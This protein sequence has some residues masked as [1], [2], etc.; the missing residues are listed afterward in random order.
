[1][2]FSDEKLMR[3]VFELAKKAEGKTSPNPLVGAIIIKDDKIISAGYHASYGTDHAEI[4]ALKKA[5]GQANDAKLY[6]NLEP[7]Y[8]F[9]LTP[10]CVDAVIKAGI[11]EVI[12]AMKDPNP[13]TNGKSIRKLIKNGIKVKVGV[14]AKEAAELNEGFVK[15]ITKRMPFV[16]AKSAQTLDGRIATKT[17]SSK[18]ITGEETYNYSRAQRDNFDA[19]LTGINTILKD[20]PCLCAPNKKLKK[21]ILDS[22]LKI[23]LKA[24]VFKKTP[25]ED[26]FIVTTKKSSP[27]KAIEIVKTGCHVIVAPEKSGRIDLKWL[28]KELAGKKIAS[29]LI[30]GGATVIGNALKNNLVDKMH[31]YVAPKIV[32]DQKALSS[33]VGFDVKDINKITNLSDL[34][35]E[36]IGKDILIKGYVLRNR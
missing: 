7:C 28:F 12:I 26:C 35:V 25:P 8:H 16:V 29:I 2:I 33:V 27:K 23:S 24:K 13:L 21:I 5:E 17:G 4:M 32:G 15:Y 11:K 20:D 1:M 22:K 10:P 3:K 31:I 36:K 6:V 18:W 9:G 14:L 34:T 19:I 30:E